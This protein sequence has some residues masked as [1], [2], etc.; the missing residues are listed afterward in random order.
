MATVRVTESHSLSPAEAKSRIT[1]FEEMI[2]KYG[3]KVDW[4]GNQAK[5]KGTGVKGSIDVTGRDAT[6]VVELGMLAR[7]AGVKADKLESSIR[8]RLRAAFDGTDAD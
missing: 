6:V 3:V 4:S 7:A 5:L 2:K 8:K 1:S